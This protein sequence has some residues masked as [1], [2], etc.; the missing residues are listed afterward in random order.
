[1]LSFCFAARR[2]GRGIFSARVIIQPITPC[3]SH[4]NIHAATLGRC[5]IYADSAQGKGFARFF[6]GAALLR[7]QKQAGWDAA[8]QK[9]HG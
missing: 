7:A 9:F 8:L 4:I 1:M 3:K 5:F 2:G 6:R